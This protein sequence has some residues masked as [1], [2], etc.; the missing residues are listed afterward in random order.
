MTMKAINSIILIGFM[1]LVVVLLTS[2]RREEHYVW[3]SDIDKQMIP[4]K[5]GDT[6]CFRDAIGDT[7][8]LIV[9]ED[10]I[11]WGGYE[12]YHNVQ[13]RYVTLTS[14]DIAMYVWV[15]G[16]NLNEN[17][18]GVAAN[19]FPMSG[20]PYDKRTGKLIAPYNATTFYD[21][22][23]IGGHIYYD[24]LEDNTYNDHILQKCYY[25]K[26]YGVLQLRKMGEKYIYTLIP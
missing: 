9:K 22:L 3:L 11:Y 8:T 24:V 16:N 10:K 23:Q 6:V 25:N 19:Y 1:G 26:A 15:H 5:L 7:I 21:S 18:V 13:E 17:T 2:C 14:K 12:E 20:I 4:Y